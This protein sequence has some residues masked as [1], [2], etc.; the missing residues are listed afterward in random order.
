[1]DIAHP[2]LSTKPLR[3]VFP[4]VDRVDLANGTTV[5]LIP[6][7]DDDIVTLSIG[8]ATG[9][10]HDEIVGETAFTAEL[11]SRGTT[12]L[13]PE[14]FAE[15][16]ESRGCSV[17][18]SA[19]RDGTSIVGVGLGEYV[20]DLVDLTVDA[21]CE[22]LFDSFEI[23]RHRQRRLA[24]YTV[25][26]SD[27]DYLANRAAS[28]AIYAGN[29]YEHPRDGTITSLPLLNTDVL[30]R[31]HQRMM[32]APRFVI[33]AGAF[34]RDRMLS[35]L[36]T[37][38]GT[39][40]TPTF[41]PTVPQS[42]RRERTAIIAP[43][44][45]AVQSVIRIGLPCVGLAHEAYPAV[46]LLTE[47]LGGYQLARLFTVLRETKGY[48]YGAYAYNDVRKFGS[49]TIITTSVGND[50]SVDTI[51]TIVEEVDKLRNVD[52]DADELFNA[53][54]ALLG[55]FAR[56]GET[57]QQT[58]G[59]VATIHQHGLRDDY[60]TR[61]VDQLQRLENDEFR[62]VRE[63]IFDS[64]TMA[65]A[66]SGREDVVRSAVANFVDTVELFNVTS[67]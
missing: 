33:A 4:Q 60:F 37:T 44:D 24:D 43:K 45:D 27:P 67:A 18:S 64:T 26:I 3:Y 53:R 59:L 10:V 62:A 47:V 56:S 19:D 5:Y 11:L 21:C 34:D 29:G 22:P 35:K 31:V 41:D 14:D 15:A 13:S 39:L 61:L 6:R 20:D 16:V 17:R 36:E 38:L 30:R 50:F 12:K 25:N 42:R 2:P 8:I 1:M 54:Q 23:D 48:T 58:A 65:I 9:S 51:A 57:P 63:Q 40:P 52:I 49:S 66:V 32:A 46:Q 28:T 55:Q 7:P